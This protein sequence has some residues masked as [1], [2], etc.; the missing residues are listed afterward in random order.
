M[1]SRLH[2]IDVFKGLLIIT[3]VIHHAPLVCVKYCNPYLDTYWINNFIIAFLCQLGLL[4][5][6][7][8]QIS[9]NHFYH[10]YGAI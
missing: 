10:I 4:P 5:L 2:Y 9:T 3:V 1:K 8:P 6:V 7:I